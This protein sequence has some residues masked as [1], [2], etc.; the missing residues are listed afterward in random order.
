MLLLG[1]LLALVAASPARAG[2]VRLWGCHGP[3]GAPVPTAYSGAG[4]NQTSVTNSAGNGCFVAGG[5]M[6]LAF[7]RPDPDNGQYAWVRFEVPPTLML[8]RVTLDR[9]ATG[10]GYVAQTP[11]KELEREDTAATLDGVVTKDAGGDYVELR[12]SCSTLAAHCDA[13]GASVS[14]RSV[15]LTVRDDTPPEITVSDVQSP[16]HGRI[17][18]LAHGQDDGVGL[19]LA[20]VTVDG[21]PA[22]TLPFDRALCRDVS[23]FDG[24][25]DLSLG[26]MCAPDGTVPIDIDTTPYADGAHRFVI[27]V[28]DGAGNTTS[29]TKDLEVRNHPVLATPTPEPTATPIP[30]PEPEPAA[31]KRATRDLVRLPAKL[32]ISRRGT[33]TLSALCPAGATSP[34]RITL[35][36]TRGKTL[37]ATG[38][39]TAAPGKRARI[40]LELAKRHC[41]AG[42]AQLTYA[43]ATPVTVRLRQ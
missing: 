11:T 28:S 40:V 31:K 16:V 27:T 34:C 36:L 22:V 6:K 4:T 5:A 42:R 12:L 20:A 3:D 35:R 21:K 10:P 25:I 37:L 39:G 23:P 38:H 18:F 13:P 29:S 1:G 32:T 26:L 19:A 15:A 14:L 8:T 30:L 33:L 17:L 7:T 43:G 9:A 24:T 41:R 2:E